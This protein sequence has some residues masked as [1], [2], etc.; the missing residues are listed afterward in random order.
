MCDKSGVG[1][2]PGGAGTGAGAGAG[3][4]WSQSQS[5]KHRDENLRR[6]HWKSVNQGQQ[7]FAQKVKLNQTKV[8]ITNK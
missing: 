6:L 1:Q 4:P 3:G 2:T 5:Q 7:S 8:N